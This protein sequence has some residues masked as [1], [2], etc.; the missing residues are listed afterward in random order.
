MYKIGILPVYVIGRGS[1]LSNSIVEIHMHFHHSFKIEQRYNGRHYVTLPNRK[2]TSGLSILLRG[3]IS[4][5]DATSCDKHSK[6]TFDCSILFLQS[7]EICKNILSISG[8]CV[9][10]K[11]DLWTAVLRI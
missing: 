7:Q 9:F 2:I 11:Q 8:G 1:I 3:V 10:L 5:P 6:N 4:L